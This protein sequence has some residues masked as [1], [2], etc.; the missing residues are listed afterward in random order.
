MY[1]IFIVDIDPNKIDCFVH[2]VSP[3]KNS[4]K[5]KYFDCKLQ[6]RSSVVKGVCFSPEKK[7][8]LEDFMHTREAVTLTKCDISNKFNV[9]NI[10]INKKTNV[11]KCTTPLNFERVDIENTTVKLSTVKSILFGQLINVKATVRQL[12]GSKI[13]STSA[14]ARLKKQEAVLVDPFG[15]IKIILWEDFVDTIETGNTYLFKNIRLKKDNYN[16]IIYVNTAMTGTQINEATAFDQPLAEESDDAQLTILSTTEITARIIGVATINFHRTCSS[17]NKA[18]EERG[19]LATCSSCNL[20]QKLSNTNNR[21]YVK[22]YVQDTTNQA[23]KVYLS[24]YHST[25][26]KLVEVADLEVDL[27]FCNEEDLTIALLD[28]TSITFCYDTAA[29]V[30]D[31]TPIIV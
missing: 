28:S 5:T 7:K 13:I 3:I 14:G 20:T 19:N 9:T 27:N 11:Q 10:V 15:S 16:N 31:V 8:H 17:C 29:K 26:V 21:W 12:S 22:L 18:I 25:L 4:G 6:T 30:T 1:S 24:L 23:N 2:Q